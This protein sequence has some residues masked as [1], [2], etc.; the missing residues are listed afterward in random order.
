MSQFMFP[1]L[2]PYRAHVYG[3]LNMVNSPT[4]PHR[5][6]AQRQTKSKP[7]I[8]QTVASQAHSEEKHE[9]RWFQ[10]T[11]PIQSINGMR[12]SAIIDIMRTNEISISIKISPARWPTHC[13]SISNVFLPMLGW[14]WAMP[15]PT[16]T[17]RPGALGFLSRK[18]GSCISKTCAQTKP[19]RE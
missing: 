16:Q 14:C 10:L 15:K 6:G 7:E 18:W 13:C 9:I 12:S 3:N 11:T 1:E 8:L 5:T 17:L 4:K 2:H 19:L